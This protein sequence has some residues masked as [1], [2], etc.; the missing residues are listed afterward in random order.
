MENLDLIIVE[1]KSTY[2]YIEM[3][4]DDK[5]AEL[6]KINSIRTYKARPY[7]TIELMKSNVLGIT[8]IILFISLAILRVYFIKNREVI[9]Q[10]IVT[11]NLSSVI[12]K[13]TNFGSEPRWLV[14]LDK[15]KIE[16]IVSPSHK[17]PF[18]KG[19]KVNLVEYEYKNGS[20][21]YAIYEKP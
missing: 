10:R 16:V 15:S 21:T 5:A 7:Y 1:T 9:G 18:N 19:K 12:A 2:P 14:K 17:S 6:S 11:G 3:R 20:F 4:R 8:L 13:E